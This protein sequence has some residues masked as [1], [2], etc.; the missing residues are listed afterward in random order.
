MRENVPRL[1]CNDLRRG[2]GAI[3]RELHRPEGGAGMFLSNEDL[4][5]CC[6]NT[7][8]GDRVLPGR[9]HLLECAKA[10]GGSVQW[11]HIGKED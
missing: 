8:R 2:P 7:G 3:Q 11:P 6:T 5:A 9:R 1:K 4:R 10:P